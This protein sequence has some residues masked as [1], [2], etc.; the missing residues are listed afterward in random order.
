MD[1]LKPVGFENR[2][3]GRHVERLKSLSWL[4]G[5][6]P[7]RWA[8]CRDQFEIDSHG[9]GYGVRRFMIESPVGR[10]V[11]HVHLRKE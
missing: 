11:E 8:P 10:H 2:L 3:V 4:Q 5:M 7:I 6:R 9:F 1:R